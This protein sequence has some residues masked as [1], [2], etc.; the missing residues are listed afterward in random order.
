MS[1]SELIIALVSMALLV[2]LGGKLNRNFVQV[3]RDSS[4]GFD[5]GAFDAGRS[6]GGIHG[7]RAAEALTPGNQTGELYDPVMLQDQ[8]TVRWLPLWR[9]RIPGVLRAMLA[10]MAIALFLKMAIRF[11]LP[12]FGVTVAVIA[13]AYWL[14][15]EGGSKGA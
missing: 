2:I 4:D 10:G 1:G 9:G 14:L 13:A 8:Q 3:C 11:S 15:W 5:Q 6:L 7:K 12:G